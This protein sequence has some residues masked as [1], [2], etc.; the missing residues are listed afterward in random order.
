LSKSGLCEEGGKEDVREGG[1]R[2]KNEKEAKYLRSDHVFT[3]N[4]VNGV[5]PERGEEVPCAHLSTILILFPRVIQKSKSANNDTN[6]GM[7]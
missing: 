1:E 4:G 7:E 3:R 5:K 2:W 6:V